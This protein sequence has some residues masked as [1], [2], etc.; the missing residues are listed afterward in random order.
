LPLDDPQLQRGKSVFMEHCH[1][2][3]PG[4]EGGL[5]LGLNDKPLPRFL[6]KTQVRLGLGVMPEFDERRISPEELD[7]LLSY[8]IALRRHDDPARSSPD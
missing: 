5:G 6:M 4:G 2:C 8:I 7:D 3:H 1:Y